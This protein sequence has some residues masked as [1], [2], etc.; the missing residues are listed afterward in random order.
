MDHGNGIMRSLQI[1]FNGSALVQIAI[2]LKFSKIGMTRTLEALSATST[3]S[4]W[5]GAS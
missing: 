2:G 1:A 5:H 4:I 3:A